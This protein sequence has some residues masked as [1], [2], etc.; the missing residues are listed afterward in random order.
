M[1]KE[2]NGSVKVLSYSHLAVLLSAKKDKEDKGFIDILTKCFDCIILD[3]IHDLYRYSLRY[4]KDDNSKGYYNIIDNLDTISAKV[5]TIGLTA[6]PQALEQL[7]NN[8][9]YVMNKFEYI[10][11]E[12]DSEL[13]EFILEHKKLPDYVQCLIINASYECGWNLKDR[14]NEISIVMIDD[15]D[16]TTQIQARSRVRHDIKTLYVKSLSTKLLIDDNNVKFAVSAKYLNKDLTKDLKEELMSVYGRKIIRS[17]ENR[18]YFDLSWTQFTEQ[19]EFSGYEVINNK[20]VK[21]GTK[22]K[23]NKNLKK[24]IG[25]YLDSKKQKELINLLDL[26][27][28]RNNR[29]I[30]SVSKINEHLKT[31][32]DLEIETARK[33][34]KGKQQ[35]IWIIKIL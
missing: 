9:Y 17:T 20:V 14:D 21:A 29:L 22:S 34:I 32:Y 10:T 6:T 8:K 33:T 11:T 28:D 5:L 2:D 3:E 13:R 27:D 18:I 31:E 12:E 19:L 1:L 7:G 24:F 26:R 35:R 30:K 15:T 4:D 25:K 23:G 16:E